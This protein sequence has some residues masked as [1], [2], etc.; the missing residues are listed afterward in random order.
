MSMEATRPGRTL[1]AGG[2]LARE[3]GIVEPA[4]RRRIRLMVELGLLFVAGPV[5]MRHAIYG[6]HIPL[7][8]V[9]LPVFL[10]LCLY[11]LWDP[12]F[13]L[14]REFAIGIS[15]RELVSIAAIFLAIGSVVAAFVALMH[16]NAFLSLPQRNPSLWVRIVIFYPLISVV[17]QELVY[18]TF[19]FHRYGPLF[20]EWRWL[21]I[22]VN[23]LLFGYAHLIFGNLISIGL[24]ALLGL[25][26]AWRYERTRSF[27]AV[28]LEHALY[29]CMVFTVGLGGYFFTGIASLR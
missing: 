4:E 27:W 1:V 5:I 25:L 13:R 15:L 29:G 20:A 21:A 3:A 24:T 16:P 28:W 8:L 14:A 18:R 17:A 22:V 11:L 6:L 19:F 12:T 9:L 7:P 23:G 10:A 2:T 26:L